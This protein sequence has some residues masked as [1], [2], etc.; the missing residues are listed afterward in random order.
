[1]TKFMTIFKEIL[2]FQC[3]TY[4]HSSLLCHSYI[5]IVIHAE[6]FHEYYQIT[7]TYTYTYYTYIYTYLM[8]SK[9]E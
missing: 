4:L 9:R 7:Y 2:L 6:V 1:M 5:C 8:N 3:Y